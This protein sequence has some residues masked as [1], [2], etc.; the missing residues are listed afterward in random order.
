MAKRLILHLT[1]EDPVECEINEMPKSGESYIEVTNPRRRDGKQLTYI[2]PGARSF[3]FP[4]TRI[5]F[6][7][8]MVSEAE[9]REVVEFF[10][11]DR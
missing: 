6:I 4:W 3:L 2:T 10:R 7:E 9:H 1:G 11:E 8:V 5:T